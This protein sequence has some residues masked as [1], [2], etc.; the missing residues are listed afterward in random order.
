[1]FTSKNLVVGNMVNL[2]SICLEYLRKAFEIQRLNK[3]IL[4]SLPVHCDI[5]ICRVLINFKSL[6]IKDCYMKN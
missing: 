1:M 3:M 2:F 6:I 4:N 5:C